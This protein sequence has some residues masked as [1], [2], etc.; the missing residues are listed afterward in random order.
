MSLKSSLFNEN[1]RNE[2]RDKYEHLHTKLKNQAKVFKKKHEI[3][4]I[5][6]NKEKE[7]NKYCN[8]FTQCNLE[9]DTHCMGIWEDIESL[10]IKLK[11]VN[12]QLNSK[13]CKEKWWY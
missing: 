5:L 12:K 9:N 10:E 6:K 7:A 13:K 11:N 4:I 8:I 1:Y 2:K 3:E